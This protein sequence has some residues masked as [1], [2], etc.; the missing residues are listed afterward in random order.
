MA[1]LPT[2]P[3]FSMQKP[4]VES[5]ALIQPKL[6]IRNEAS[7]NIMVTTNYEGRASTVT[8]AAGSQ[9]EINAPEKL[10]DLAIV[11]QGLLRN[12]TIK[13]YDQFKAALRQ[14]QTQKKH[15]LLDITRSSSW[16]TPLS[17]TFTFAERCKSVNDDRRTL[18]D[19]F[20]V[21]K[22]ARAAGQEIFPYHYFGFTQLPTQEDLEVLY[23]RQKDLFAKL[24]KQDPTCELYQE[25][26]EL[27]DGMHVRI[28][29][30]QQTDT[31]HRTHYLFLIDYFPY[32][33]AALETAYDPL[34]CHFLN[35]T[36]IPA[37]AL[38][39]AAYLRERHRLFDLIKNNRQDSVFYKNA[40][41]CVQRA[42]QCLIGDAWAVQEFTE[43]IQDLLNT[44]QD[45]FVAIDT[46]PLT[47]TR[48]K[49]Y[50]PSV[51]EAAHRY[52]EIRPELVLDVPGNS[53]H[54]LIQ[55]AYLEKKE[56]L[57]SLIST[58]PEPYNALYK[59]A[60]RFV[61][62]AYECLI[63]GSTSAL[64]AQIRFSD[65]VTEHIYTNQREYK[66]LPELVGAA[67]K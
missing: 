63:G 9:F 36:Q 60:L 49:H 59:D 46:R 47:C 14:A 43:Y 27:L 28:Q 38:L 7:Q 10:A 37:P 12:T 26:L 66:A 18:D 45:Y 20:P 51:R 21:A 3:L 22:A 39:H 29:K 55:A 17:V 62:Y 44:P 41:Q 8:L 1:L 32:A 5:T 50:F 23:T 6:T 67:A 16:S 64:S 58:T 61:Q 4:C 31:P 53:S 35:L 13:A 42:Y 40:L 56:E 30:M 52:E 34:P 25:A 57:E 48:L 15:L 11:H 33:K 65:F 24:L 2:V 19:L 54:E